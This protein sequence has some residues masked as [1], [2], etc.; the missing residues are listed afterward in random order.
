MK[1][2]MAPKMTQRVERFRREIDEID[3]MTGDRERETRL[4]RSR[5]EASELVK[6]ALHIVR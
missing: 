5:V 1:A 4:V 2:L 6:A 3:P